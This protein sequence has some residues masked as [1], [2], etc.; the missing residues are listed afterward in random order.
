MIDSTY[1]I[2]PGQAVDLNKIA[3]DD[4]GSFKDKNAAVIASQEHLQRLEK[5]QQSLYAEGKRSL[6]V[7]LQ[8]MDTGGKDGTIRHVFSGVNPQGCS[9]VSF[10]TPSSEELAHDYLWRIHKAAPARGMITIFNRSHYESVLIER[11]HKL[12]PKEVWQRRYDHINAFEKLLTDEGTVVLK[13]F[14]HISKHEQLNRLQERQDDPK[15]TWKFQKGDFAERK[16]WKKYH[17]AYEDALT[18]CSTAHAPW[19]IIPADHKWFRNWLISDILVRTLEKMNP[20]Y[21]R[22]PVE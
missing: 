10:K 9:V 15:K 20:R 21:P 4:T 6:L 19:Y 22:N 8:A 2:G 13:F 16:L 14:L 1:K 3:T 12:V 5:L 11:V 7:V 18:R 17:N